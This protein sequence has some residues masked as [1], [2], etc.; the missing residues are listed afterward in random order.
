LKSIGSGSEIENRDSHRI[1]VER[2]A[3]DLRKRWRLTADRITEGEDREI[4][5]NDIAA[6]VEK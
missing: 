1:V 2:L 6:F 3:F 5:F 4:R